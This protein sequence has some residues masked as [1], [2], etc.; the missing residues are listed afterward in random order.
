[1]YIPSTHWMSTLIATI[2]D[3]EVVIYTIVFFTMFDTILCT[4]ITLF[5]FKYCPDLFYILRL[6]IPDL[7]NVK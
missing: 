6:F 1:M 2:L 7:L 3:L 5:I 4:Y